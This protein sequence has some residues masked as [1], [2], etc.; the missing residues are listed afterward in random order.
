MSDYRF[1]TQFL[2]TPI[3]F[4]RNITKIS[5]KVIDL[6]F[7]VRA[8]FEVDFYDEHDILCFTSCYSMRDEEYKNWNND[9]DYVYNM[10]IKNLD[11]IL[12]KPF[13]S[14]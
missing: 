4:T 14:A 8:D 3:S 2:E 7:K 6:I 12:Y 10:I 13:F 11:N 1:T 5:Y 9:D